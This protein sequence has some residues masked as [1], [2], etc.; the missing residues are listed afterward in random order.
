M[1]ILSKIKKNTFLSALNSIYRN[2]FKATRRK[3][4][5]IHPTA[6]YRQPILIKGIENVCLHE[7][8]SILGHA[9]I[10]TTNAKFIIKKNSGAAEGL[11]VVTGNHASY[12][13]VWHRF[14]TDEQKKGEGMDKDVIVEEDVW[15][16]TNVTLLSGVTVGRGS[17]VG[18]GAVVR[19]NVPP[20]ALVFG[21][22]AK[23]VG[24]KFTPK[25]IIE[26]EIAL[27]PEEERLPLELLEKNHQ[28]YF[29]NRIKDIKDYIKI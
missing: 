10:L 18:S 24:F 22:P 21:N 20:Y 27:Y 11:T 4:G 29:K 16:A 15:I 3:F 19:N 14:I 23:V 25:E 1:G 9:V 7:N 12:V 5:Y 2:Y 6:F 8:T 17:I 28:K 26:H 13:G